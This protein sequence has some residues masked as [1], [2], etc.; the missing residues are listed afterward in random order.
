MILKIETRLIKTE[1]VFKKLLGYGHWR[2]AA[3]KTVYGKLTRNKC[4]KNETN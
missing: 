2:L 1:L 3:N 4:N